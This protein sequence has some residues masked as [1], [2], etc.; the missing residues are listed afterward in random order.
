M[1]IFDLFKQ[2]ESQNTAVT[3]PPAYIIA[4]L[5]NIGEKYHNTRHNAGFMM[6]DA[7][8]QILLA[9]PRLIQAPRGIETMARLTNVEG[10]SD[11]SLC[12]HLSMTRHQHKVA[13]YEEDCV[14]HLMIIFVGLP[15]CTLM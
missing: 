9:D 15:F 3:G 12:H 10:N 4:G 11:V 6:I 13:D 7:F 1:S 8:A 2:I 5:G 14:F